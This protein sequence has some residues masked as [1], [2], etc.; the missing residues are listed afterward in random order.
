M[1]TYIIGDV[2]GC[3]SNLQKL[4]EKIKF[5]PDRDFVWFCGDLINRGPDN[6]RTLQLI[7]ELDNKYQAANTVLGNHD[8]HLISC[9]FNK[10]FIT[11]SDNFLDIL[12]DRQAEQYIYYLLTKPL[13]YYNQKQNYCL[14]HAGINPDWDLDLCQKLNQEYC[15]FIHNL[16]PEHN[17]SKLKDFFDSLYGNYPDK[18]QDDLSHY[19][20]YRIII[21]SFTRMRFLDKNHRLLLDYKGGIPSAPKEYIPWFATDNHKLISKQHPTLKIFF[22]HWAALHGDTKQDNIIGLDTGCVYGGELTAYHVD[23]NTKIA[24]KL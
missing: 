21:N 18:W 7:Y 14:A 8:L 19:D 5:N 11:K 9:Y 13:F 3:Y 4:L 15:D 12:N 10:K 20:R 24:I 6:L 1:N 17:T 23:T 22:G 16:T 2:Q